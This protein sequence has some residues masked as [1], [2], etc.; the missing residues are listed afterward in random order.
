MH[1]WA[2]KL[3]RPV[4][5]LA[6]LI[7]DVAGIER[8]AIAFQVREGTGTLTVGQVIDAR[9]AAPS[10]GDTG[11]AAIPHDDVCTTLPGSETHLGESATYRVHSP[12]YGFDLDLQNYQVMQGRFRFEG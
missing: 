10:H 9:L 12:T 8:A 4:A 5:D 2:G 6:Q 1:V 7:G 3:G 11:P